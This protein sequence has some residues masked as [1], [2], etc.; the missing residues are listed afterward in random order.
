MESLTFGA[1]ILTVQS[2]LSW[3]AKKALNIILL[4]VAISAVY[5][6]LPDDPFRSDIISV[7]GTFEQWSDFINWLVPTSFIVTSTLFAVM[8]KMFYYLYKLIMSQLGAN[9]IEHIGTS[10]LWGS[11][12]TWDDRD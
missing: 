3:I 4:M 11:T 9:F 6:L 5:P 7:S 12:V 1:F 2:F 10:E 8:C